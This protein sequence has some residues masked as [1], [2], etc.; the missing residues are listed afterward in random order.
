MLNEKGETICTV[1]RKPI[2]VGQV[3]IASGKFR[4][5]SVPQ[6]GGLTMPTMDRVDLISIDYWHEECIG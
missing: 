3:V 2:E 4:V 6:F 5:K 1:C